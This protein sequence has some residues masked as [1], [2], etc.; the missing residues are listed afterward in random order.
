MTPRALSAPAG[1]PVAAG[2]PASVV[3]ATA[4]AAVALAWLLGAAGRAPDNVPAGP[5]RRPDPGRPPS[6]R[7]SRAA[8]VPDPESVA[9]AVDLLVLVLRSG[10]GVVEGIEAVAGAVHGVTGRE[11]RSVAAALRWGLPPAAAWSMPSPVWQPVARALALAARAGA[12]P[13]AL[14]EQSADELRRGEDARLEQQ[15]AALGVRV[16]LPLGL[17]F[18]PGFF[19]TTVVPVVLALA[20]EVLREA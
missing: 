8:A 7:P 19:L 2:L 18:L 16:V 10:G 14:L 20:A 3:A 17:A 4:A 9:D 1:L 6:S 5:A 13:A 12:P 11:L 15:T